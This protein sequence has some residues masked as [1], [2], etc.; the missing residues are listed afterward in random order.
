MND[1]DDL[2]FGVDDI[3]RWKRRELPED[4][5]TNRCDILLA[6][7]RAASADCDQIMSRPRPDRMAATPSTLCPSSRGESPSQT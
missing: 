2:L 1:D 5:L 7:L 4:W 3:N 6:R